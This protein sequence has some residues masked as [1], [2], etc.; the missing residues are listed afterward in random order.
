MLP[1]S[2]PV[3]SGPLSPFNDLAA[4]IWRSQFDAD[5]IM[6]LLLLAGWVWWREGGGVKGDIIGFFYVI[7]G[8]MFSFPYLLYLIAQNQGGMRAVLLGVNGQSASA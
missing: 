8:G 5:L 1:R 2:T 7:W 3:L 6:H 4:L